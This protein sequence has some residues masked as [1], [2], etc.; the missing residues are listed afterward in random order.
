MLKITLNIFFSLVS[1]SFTLSLTPFPPLP[2]RHQLPTVSVQYIAAVCV[3]PMK[4][5]TTEKQFRITAS[6]PTFG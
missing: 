6:T 3:Q 4:Y 5:N 1:K 2:H